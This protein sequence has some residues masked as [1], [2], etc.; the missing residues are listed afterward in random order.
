M[1]LPQREGRP[2]LSIAPDTTPDTAAWN[3]SYNDPMNSLN[4]PVPTRKGKPEPNGWGWEV[5]DVTRT[6]DI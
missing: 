2:A 1:S 6:E 3:E 5:A 4:K